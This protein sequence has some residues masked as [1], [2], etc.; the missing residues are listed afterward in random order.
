MAH[1]FWCVYGIFGLVACSYWNDYAG[2]EDDNP[3]E[4]VTEAVIKYETGLDIDLTPR[5][6]E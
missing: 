2:W 5:S 1:F 6:P 4:E 3:A